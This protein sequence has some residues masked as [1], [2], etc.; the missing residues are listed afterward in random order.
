MCAFHCFPRIFMRRLSWRALVE[1]H[2]DIC[3]ER[4]L[5]IHHILWCEEMLRTIEVRTKMNSFFRHFR[6]P[7][8]AIRTSSKSERKNLKSSRI[9]QNR[10]IHIHEVMKSTEWFYHLRSWLQIGMIIVHK[11]DLRANI[12]NLI[13]RESLQGWA[14]SNRHEY[15]RL[16]FPV[17][18][19]DLAGA[20]ESI[21]CSDRERKWWMSHK[22]WKF[23]EV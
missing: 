3:T 1:R 16:D 9:R 12:A 14:G 15:W 18:G 2:D 13:R 6:E 20:S 11:H 19:R 7:I 21:G 10:K 22:K 4:W 8:S 17:W 5:H 23:H